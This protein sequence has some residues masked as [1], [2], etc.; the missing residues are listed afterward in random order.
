MNTLPAL[1]G[2]SDLSGNITHS[3]KVGQKQRELTTEAALVQSAAFSK[4]F[5]QDL[6]SRIALEKARHGNYRAAVEILTILAGLAVAKAIGPKTN[7][8]GTPGT[9]KKGAVLNLAEKTLDK[10]AGAKGFS[11]KALR[12]RSFASA[13]IEALTAPMEKAPE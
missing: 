4:A 13:L 2:M 10:P 8:D 12:I 1:R 11:T 3:V 6:P 5:L 9:W 7:D